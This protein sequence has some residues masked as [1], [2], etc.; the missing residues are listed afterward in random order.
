MLLVSI[1]RADDDSGRTV[2]DWRTG[3]VGVRDPAEL[4]ACPHGLHRIPRFHENHRCRGNGGTRPEGR[5]KINA[6]SPDHAPGWIYGTTAQW[7]V[8]AAYLEL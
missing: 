6:G 8:A 3:V 2:K 7:I 1:L 5:K 4:R